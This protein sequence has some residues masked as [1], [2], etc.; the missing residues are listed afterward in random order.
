MKTGIKFCGGCNPRY[1]RGAYARRLTAALS[2]PVELAKPETPYDTVYVICGC[3]ARCADISAL[4]AR[5][6]IYVTDDGKVLHEIAGNLSEQKR[7][8]SHR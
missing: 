4:S 3:H 6:F 1:D 2:D 7:R 5:R 8:D